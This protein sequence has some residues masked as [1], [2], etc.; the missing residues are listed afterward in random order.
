MAKLRKSATRSIDPFCSKSFLKKRA[1]SMFTPMAANTIAKLSDDVSLHTFVDHINTNKQRPIGL[2]ED[3][4]YAL[5]FLLDQTS[6]STDL[7]G[8]L[9]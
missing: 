1:V 5:A 4:L 8:D 6:L 3:V 9:Q 7:G 2:D